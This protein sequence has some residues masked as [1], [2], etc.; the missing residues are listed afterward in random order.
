M[1]IKR[2]HVIEC[3]HPRAREKLPGVGK[4]TQESLDLMGV[5]T[6]AQLRLL[7]FE[8]LIGKFGKFGQRLFNLA[9]GIDHSEVRSNRPI[10]SI[11]SEHTFADD[12]KLNELDDGVVSAIAQTWNATEKKNR[13]GK[14]VIVKLKTSEL[15]SITRSSTP[16][17][18]PMSEHDL[19][20]IARELI[21][22]VELPD[23]TRYRL[24]GVGLS[25]FIENEPDYDQ[26][27]LFN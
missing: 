8:D 17:L 20:K 21:A 24:V 12:L 25:N 23:S 3:L 2:V 26:P 16:E 10:K 4:R 13:H 14:T 27:E 6:V 22:R 9:R 5:K 15:K 11:S 18:R 7:S 1:N 19:L